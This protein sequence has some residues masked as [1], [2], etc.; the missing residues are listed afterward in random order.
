VDI[1]GA[2]PSFG[3]SWPLITAGAVN[4]SFAALDASNSPP[5]PRGLQYQVQQAGGDVSVAVGN[6]LILTID[7][8]TG[9]GVVE[10][11]V[12]GP[13]DFNGYTL[14]SASGFL[15]PDGWSSLASSG[16]GGPAWEVANP[17][18][19]HLSELNLT[20][21]TSLAV[22][23]SLT[24]GSPY[25]P[26]P[27]STAQEDV[28]FEYIRA[29]G[30]LVQAIVEYTGPV[31]DL[32]LNV[33]PETGA[34]AISKLSPFFPTPEVKGYSIRSMSGSMTPNSWIGFQDSGNAGDGWEEANPQPD[35]LSE[36]NLDSSTEFA[37]NTLISLGNFFAPGGTPDLVFE[38]ITAAGHVLLG[39]VEYGEIPVVM[40]GL[41]G[42][43]NLDGVVDRSDI[44][45]LGIEIAGSTN[46]AAFDLTGDNLVNGADRDVFLGD[47][48][49]S[50]G[51][52]L[53]GDA[54]F[55]GQVQF[56]DF[57]I[58]ADNFAQMAK[59]WSEG[60]FDTDGQVQ[61]PDFVILADNF[62]MSAA[63]AASV[64]EP[65]GLMLGLMAVCVGTMLRG[66]PARS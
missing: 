38:Y 20:E 37:T 60:D 11:V 1:S 57:V 6:S 25:V 61:F 27:H 59:K 29:D 26:G 41:R 65:S 18:A 7:R 13:V 51:N 8:L 21:A 30:N 44:D 9:S 12:G 66:R 45:L 53:N 14:K 5:L 58:L 46:D 62:G 4:G 49:I 55:S 24:I 63:A 48:I 28:Q 54:D 19:T 52:K 16:A 39:T 10:N 47:N 35:H 23:D 64:P 50:D 3:Q 43:F 31:A 36:L 34:G 2:A 56:P 40:P 42:D 22:G 15:N 32:V 33:D 17:Q